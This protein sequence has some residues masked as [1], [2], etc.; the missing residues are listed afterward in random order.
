MDEQKSAQSPPRCKCRVS[1]LLGSLAAIA[2]GIYYLV[3]YRPDVVTASQSAAQSFY[4]STFVAATG[5]TQQH[6]DDA[7]GASLQSANSAVRSGAAK[8]KL[9]ASG[10]SPLTDANAPSTAAVPAIVRQRFDRLYHTSPLSVQFWNT[11]NMVLEHE[12]AYPEA[13][14]FR[15][16][17]LETVVTPFQLRTDRYRRLYLAV[18]LS[19]HS[20]LMFDVSIV[21]PF[22]VFLCLCA[23]HVPLPE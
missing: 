9:A 3:S 16:D 2:V 23:F 5:P 18:F 17:L 4:Q 22:R 12:D 14:V 19:P 10:R 11:G 20:L 7:A 15:G 1:V 6:V 8:P 21:L 13:K